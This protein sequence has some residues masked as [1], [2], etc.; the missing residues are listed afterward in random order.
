MI[1][2]NNKDYITVLIEASRIE[3]GTI[4]YKP[5]GDIQYRLYVDEP[6]YGSVINTDIRRY[7]TRNGMVYLMHDNGKYYAYPKNK[8]LRV[9]ID[10]YDLQRIIDETSE[11]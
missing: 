1:D 4:V 2:L 9:R 7:G 5:T 8:F 3:D 10:K 6:G 11:Y